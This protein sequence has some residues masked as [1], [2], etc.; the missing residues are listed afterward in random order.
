MA[1]HVLRQDREI[2][3]RFEL[4]RI[5]KNNKTATLALCRNNEPYVVTLTYGYDDTLKAL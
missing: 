1:Y 2:K 3:D 4:D 5:I